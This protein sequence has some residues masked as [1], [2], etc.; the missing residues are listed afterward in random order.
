MRVLVT[1]ATGFVGHWLIRELEAAG[2]QAIAAPGSRELDITDA[3]AVRELVARVRP[4]AIAHLAAVSYAGDA[5]RDPARAVAVN[6][7]GTR[8]VIEAAAALAHVDHGAP[9][10][11]VVG[12]SE[13]YGHPDPESLP[14]SES[15]PLRT[16][17]PYGLSK[18]AQERVALRLGEELGVRVAVARSFN[19][20]GPGQRADFVAPAL[21][22]RILAA[23]AAGSGEVVV[24]NLDVRRDLGD[25]RDVVRAYRLLLEGLAGNSV[26]SGTVVNVATGRSVSIRSVLETLAR[27]AGADVTPRV[28][29][30]LVRPNDPPEIVGDATLLRRLTGWQAAIPIETTL[31]DLMASVEQR[32]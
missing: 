8:A 11:L 3:V 23:R 7:G 31:A 21:A 28:D 9:A 14:L 24:G 6:E 2:H 18:L 10:V 19:H 25:V 17:Q 29:P 12:S 22:R 5:S 26:A 13:V 16:D 20:T 32:R 30:A 27:A 4:D 1:G 15:A